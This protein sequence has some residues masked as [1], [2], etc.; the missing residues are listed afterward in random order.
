MK[1]HTLAYCAVLAATLSVATPRVAAQQSSQ[2][3]YIVG[4]KYSIHDVARG[5]TLYSLARMYGITV[6]DITAANP[7]LSE[8]LKAGQRIKIPVSAPAKQEKRKR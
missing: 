8:G 7:A 1:L 6:D 5:E 4:V 3:V 2:I